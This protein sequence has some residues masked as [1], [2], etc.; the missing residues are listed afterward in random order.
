MTDNSPYEIQ[1]FNSAPFKSGVPR[2]RQCVVQGHCTGIHVA[3]SPFPPDG[4]SASSGNKPGGCGGGQTQPPS[5]LPPSRAAGHGGGPGLD[6]MPDS[7]LPPPSSWQSRSTPPRWALRGECA[8]RGCVAWP[9]EFRRPGG[10]SAGRVRTRRLGHDPVSSGPASRADY[11]VQPRPQP[12]SVATVTA[13]LRVKLR[14]RRRAEVRERARAGSGTRRRTRGPHWQPSLAAAGSGSSS[15][16]VARPGAAAGGEGGLPGAPLA[17]A[18]GPGLLGIG[19]CSSAATL[20][21]DT[22]ILRYLAGNRPA[23]WLDRIIQA[24]RG[25]LLDRT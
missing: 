7:A 1:H 6:T 24:R 2:L 11:L 3:G 25:S 21:S 20:Q 17:A 10:G 14:G 18:R 23:G 5:R 15:W 12:L 13:A 9:R 8:P 19:L 16:R 22:A 4:G